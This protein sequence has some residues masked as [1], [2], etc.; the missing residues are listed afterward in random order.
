MDDKVGDTPRKTL[1]HYALLPLCKKTQQNCK[2]VLFESLNSGVE[3][4][5]FSH[6]TTNSVAV[7][8]M[9]SLFLIKHKHKHA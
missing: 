9:S 5:N 3:S 4:L 6:G 1:H 7:S 2:G 8:A